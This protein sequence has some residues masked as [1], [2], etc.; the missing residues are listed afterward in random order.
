MAYLAKKEI[1]QIFQLVIGQQL[2]GFMK[3]YL[4]K[5]PKITFEG[6]SSYKDAFVDYG[7]KS[8]KQANISINQRTLNLIGKVTIN[9][10]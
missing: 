6:K 9:Q 10:Y 8:E 5:K 1:S 4:A 7:V 2:Q 3:E